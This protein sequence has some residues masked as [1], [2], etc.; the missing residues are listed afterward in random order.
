[1]KSKIIKLKPRTFVEDTQSSTSLLL[2]EFIHDRLYGVPDPK[3]DLPGGYFIQERHQVGRLREPIKFTKCRGYYDFRQ[4]ME[5][6]YPE[7]AWVTP[8]ELFKPYYSY[9]IANF[10]LN[11]IIDK[12]ISLKVLEIGP[13]TGTFAD[14]CLDFFKNYDLD[15][16][17][18]SEYTFCEI[19][20]QLAESCEKTMQQNHK[21]LL[22]EGRIKIYNSSIMDFEQR[23]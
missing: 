19:S 4:E 21:K 3:N 12:K 13:G 1:M 9:T 11:Q 22:D 18:N 14:S 8:C 5:R 17:R 16:Y 6:L 20:P 15:L 10:M 2:R 7:N 23:I